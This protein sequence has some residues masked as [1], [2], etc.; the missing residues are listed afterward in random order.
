M[1]YCSF[2]A[3]V[4]THFRSKDLRT[5]NVTLVKIATALSLR[6]RGSSAEILVAAIC[7][8]VTVRPA[9]ASEHHLEQGPRM[10]AIARLGSPPSLAVA[11]T[12]LTSLSL[13][14]LDQKAPR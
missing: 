10:L 14:I 13:R 8:S 9:N 4:E 2:L 12:T 7:H 5:I 1:S 11:A 3:R 6:Q